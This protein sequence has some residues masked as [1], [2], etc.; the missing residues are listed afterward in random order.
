M[1][2]SRVYGSG[3][4]R[5]ARRSR[6]V[7]RTSEN[8]SPYTLE[9]GE[10][11]DDF[12]QRMRPRLLQ[13]LRSSRI[14]SQDAEDLLQNTFAA[15]FARW[16]SVRHKEAWLIQTV[17]C[18]C[19]EYW[20]QHRLRRMVESVDPQGLD[21][22]CEPQPPGQETA[23][24]ALDLRRLT[25]GLEKKHRAILWLR[26]G[27]GLSDS[28]VARSL[29]YCPSSVRKLSLR[30]LARLRKEV[31]RSRAGRGQPPEPAPGPKPA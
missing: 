18:G 13:I 15:A 26:L 12:L 9:S 27:R 25:R 19:W 2:K 6:T 24:A 23:E 11:L 31:A 17:R 30:S 14:P 1:I 20:R 21:Q 22:F 8:P 16:G 10:D 7:T 4:P 29:G 28:E 3:A 5:A